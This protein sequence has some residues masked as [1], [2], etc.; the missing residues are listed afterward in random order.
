VLQP[1]IDVR[2]VTQ[3]ILLVLKDEANGTTI[4]GYTDLA[5]FIE[6]TPD[7]KVCAFVVELKVNLGGKKQLNQ[8]GDEIMG[9]MA[10]NADGDLTVDSIS[11][12]FPS[13]CGFIS[14]GHNGALLTNVGDVDGKMKFDFATP[15]ADGT[16]IVGLVAQQMIKTVELRRIS[17]LHNNEEMK[18]REEFNLLELGSD[19]AGSG[20]ADSDDNAAGTDTNGAPDAG[21]GADGNSDDADAGDDDGASTDGAPRR[22]ARNPSGSSSKVLAL[23]DATNTA[24]QNGVPVKPKVRIYMPP[25]RPSAPQI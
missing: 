21:D 8:L 14:D 10:R 11:R 7:V 1:E 9:M 19:D 13:C 18:R 6:Y 3:K 24:T 20:G 4:I 25:R 22:S 5:G 12:T 15:G 23:G 17:L 2:D 16:G